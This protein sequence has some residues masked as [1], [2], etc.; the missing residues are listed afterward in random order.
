[1]KSK[2][3]LMGNMNTFSEADQLKVEQT[4]NLSVMNLKISPYGFIYIFFRGINA[5]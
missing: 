1:M 5:E 4:K 2:L 3:N